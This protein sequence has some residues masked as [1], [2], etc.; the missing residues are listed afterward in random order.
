MAIV[1]MVLGFWGVRK[2]QQFGEEIRDPA[3]RE[4]KALSALGANEIPAG[5]HAVVAFSI[6]FLLEVAVLSDVAPNDSGRPPEIGEHGFIYVSHPVL[7]KDQRKIR[8]F[9]EGKSVDLEDLGGRR[10]DMDLD[11]RIANGRFSRQGDEVLWVCHRGTVDT[12]DTGSAN[13]GLISLLLIDCGDSRNRLGIWLGPDPD[14]AAE[15]AEL[16]LAGTVADPAAIESFLGP[17]QPCR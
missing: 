15:P 14:P 1:L 11:Q 7:R 12:D 8:D 10:I 17:I 5:Y 3:T 13:Q 4:Q 9:F 16:D 6:P 2:A